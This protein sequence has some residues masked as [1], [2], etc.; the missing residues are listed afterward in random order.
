MQPHVRKCFEAVKTLEMKDG[1][2]KRHIE[3][4]G[5]NSPEK[6]YIPLASNVICQGAVEAW[7]LGI[8]TAMVSTMTQL[9]FR[10][11]SD[12]KK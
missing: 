3:A 12:M 10:C 11:Y 2:G 1:P 6:E 8:E 4:I 9:L 5:L 7:L